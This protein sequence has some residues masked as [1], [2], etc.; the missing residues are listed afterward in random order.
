LLQRQLGCFKIFNV[1]IFKNIVSPSLAGKETIC[2]CPYIFVSKWWPI[3]AYRFQK[4][5]IE[6]IETSK[7]LIDSSFV[8]TLSHGNEKNNNSQIYTGQNPIV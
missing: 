2:T 5:I 8:E 3:H 1:H 7:F 6:E 4:H